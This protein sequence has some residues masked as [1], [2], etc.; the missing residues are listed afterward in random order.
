MYFKISPLLAR[1][2]SNRK[3][4]SFQVMASIS[5]NTW[6]LGRGMG[7]PNVD[8]KTPKMVNKT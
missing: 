3:L 8:E 4:T 1:H 7:A 2:R 6:D 5:G